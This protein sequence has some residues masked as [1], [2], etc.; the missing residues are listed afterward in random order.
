VSRGNYL[1]ANT[2]DVAR[3]PHRTLRN[4]VR[5]VGAN[6]MDRKTRNQLMI[7]EKMST[8]FTKERR[9]EA[10]KDFQSRLE[11]TL[12]KKKLKKK[13]LEKRF[14]GYDFKPKVN[15]KRID[16]YKNN[17]PAKVVKTLK[18]KQRL[19]NAR[20]GNLKKTARKNKKPYMRKKKTNSHQNKTKKIIIQKQLVMGDR[21]EAEPTKENLELVNGVGNHDEKLFEMSSEKKGQ[22][23]SPEFN[24]SERPVVEMDT[25]DDLS[26]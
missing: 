3:Y 19:S 2:V 7:E 22:V 16:I 21:I 14:Y 25:E 12:Q 18:K 17:L 11:L 1:R 13:E 26:H 10:L 5:P 23:E 24:V 15:K 4:T 8:L 6:D 9:V 20:H